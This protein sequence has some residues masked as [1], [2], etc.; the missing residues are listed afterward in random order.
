ML[1]ATILVIA[2]SFA[3]SCASRLS[4]R[5]SGPRPRAVYLLLACAC[6][7]VA[8]ACAI[9]GRRLGD[10]A[11]WQADA[12]GEAMVLGGGLAVVMFGRAVTWGWVRRC[13]W[14]H[15][16]GGTGGGR[17]SAVANAPDQAQG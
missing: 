5:T 14:L 9:I 10:Q 15:P 17:A 1:E 7:A 4:L 3:N 16:P 2:A 8:A 13:F 12:L 6:G 11:G